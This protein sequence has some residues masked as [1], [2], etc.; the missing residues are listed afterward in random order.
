MKYNIHYRFTLLKKKREIFFFHFLYFLYDYH[1]IIVYEKYIWIS[2]KIIL[3]IHPIN[4]TNNASSQKRKILIA[5]VKNDTTY[6]KKISENFR[7]RTL[8]QSSLC[9]RSLSL[10]YPISFW[11]SENGLGFCFSPPRST[12]PFGLG[13]IL[14]ALRFTLSPPSF[15]H[16]S[17][18]LFI[19][20]TPFNFRALFKLIL[21]IPRISPCEY[22]CYLF[23]L[24]LLSF[25]IEQVSERLLYFRNIININF[26]HAHFTEFNVV[27]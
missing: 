17:F 2:S 11:I 24:F 23:S 10:I 27:F 15:F 7:D 18:P 19:H 20:A 26:I 12:F 4:L 13:Y 5:K 21:S 3:Q 1:I 8:R 25:V 9:L 22:Y 6:A 16:P 14:C